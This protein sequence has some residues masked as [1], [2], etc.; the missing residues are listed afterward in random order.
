MYQP[1]Y[2]DMIPP[3]YAEA[4]NEVRRDIFKEMDKFPPSELFPGEIIDMHKEVL[5]A[6]NSIL[7]D[8][9][10]HYWQEDWSTT[11]ERARCYLKNIKK[12]RPNG[13]ERHKRD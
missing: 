10:T 8:V 2:A 12:W 4:L 1:N 7:K 3:V 9:L 6:V 13:A 5:S 11:L